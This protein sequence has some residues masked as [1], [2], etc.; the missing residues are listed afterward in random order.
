MKKRLGCTLTV[1][2]DKIYIFGGET[3]EETYFN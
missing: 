3:E 1:I 2:K